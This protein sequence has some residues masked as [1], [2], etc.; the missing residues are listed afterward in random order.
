VRKSAAFIALFLTF[1]TITPVTAITFESVTSYEGYYGYPPDYDPNLPHAVIEGYLVYNGGNEAVPYPWDGSPPAYASPTLDG[2]RYF[3]LPAG[4]GPHVLTIDEDLKPGFEGDLPGTPL[5]ASGPFV[6]VREGDRVEVLAVEY[7][8]LIRPSSSCEGPPGTLYAFDVNDTVYIVGEPDVPTRPIRVLTTP[9]LGVLF[10]SMSDGFLVVVREARGV[11]VYLVDETFSCRDPDA[12]SMFTGPDGHLWT[13]AVFFNLAVLTDG[14]SLCVYTL[15]GPVLEVRKDLVVVNTPEGPEIVEVTPS[16]VV[17][18]KVSAVVNGVVVAVFEEGSLSE[19]VEVRPDGSVAEFTV[20]GRPLALCDGVLVCEGD[21][22]YRAYEVGPSGIVAPCASGD[23]DGHPYFAF[24]DGKVVVVSGSGVAV[25]T[26]DGRPEAA[27]GP[28]LELSNHMAV[29]VTSGGIVRPCAWNVEVSVFPDGEVV[30]CADDRPVPLGRIEGR[31][32]GLMGSVLVTDSGL[33]Y[34]ASPSGL[35]RAEV[36]CS[37][38]DV[39]VALSGDSVVFV[40]GDA[41]YVYGLPGRP[42]G[43]SVSGRFVV[44]ETDEGPAAFEVLPAGVSRPDEGGALPGGHGF[45]FGDVVVAVDDDGNVYVYKINGKVSW[46][47][48]ISG[49]NVELLTCRGPV[50]PSWVVG[51]SYVFAV[52]DETWVVEVVDGK[53]VRSA[54]LP[55]RPVCVRGNVLLVSDGDVSTPYVLGPTGPVRM[56]KVGDVEG[57]SLYAGNGLMVAVRGYVV[58]VLGDVAGPVSVCR[59]AVVWLAPGGP[60]AVFVVEGEVKKP[61]ARVEVGPSVFFVGPDEGGRFDVVGWEAGNV[62]YFEVEGRFMGVVG[63]VVLYEGEDGSVHRLELI[64]PSLIVKLAPAGL[65]TRVEPVAAPAGSDGEAWVLPVLPPL[66]RRYSGD[67][68]GGRGGSD[69]V[70]DVDDE[71]TGD[72]RL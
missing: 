12:V 17:R 15:P 20:P 2:A 9:G 11:S 10:K 3:L 21:S 7:R 62:C 41:A 13:L 56:S 44:V 61:V 4:K 23:T 63:D 66:G 5:G 48:V 34:V 37:V 6:A 19:V 42:S 64:T 58:E 51:D 25:F 45:L 46:P 28:Y 36:K 27:C 67:P 54:R 69:A 29:E 8:G 38:G 40:Y 59:D 22:G 30:W 52:G 68:E 60:E 1:T 70:S 47:V 53:V 26:I 32:I 35:E 65:S 14:G 43:V 55:G 24:E 72:A 39:K 31:V 57:V 71:E 33:V 49:E 18:P 16:G 50:G